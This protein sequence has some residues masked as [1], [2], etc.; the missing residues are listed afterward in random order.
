M[1]SARIYRYCTSYQTSDSLPAAMPRGSEV[2]ICKDGTHYVVGIPDRAPLMKVGQWYW[3]AGFVVWYVFNIVGRI[4]ILSLG[5]EYT[6]SLSSAAL[7]A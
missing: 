5:E 4:R 3:E 7:N 2:I 1:E 6:S